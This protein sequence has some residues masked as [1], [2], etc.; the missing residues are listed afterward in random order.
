L[1]VDALDDE[2]TLISDGERSTGFYQ[3]IPSCTRGVARRASINKEW[4]KTLL[5]R[6]NIRTPEGKGVS[7]RSQGGRLAVC[8]E[9][10][11]QG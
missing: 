11:R 9:T 10:Q 7:C 6:A 4:T 3:G 1:L 5:Q 8:A 2:F